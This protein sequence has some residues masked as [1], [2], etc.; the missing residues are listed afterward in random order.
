MKFANSLCTP[1]IIAAI[2]DFSTESPYL[3]LRLHCA[4]C[5]INKA[6]IFGDGFMGDRLPE[7][8]HFFC[9]QVILIDVTAHPIF[10]LARKFVFLNLTRNHYERHQ[11]I[12]FPWKKGFYRSTQTGYAV[13]TVTMV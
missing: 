13:Y 5:V 1:I 2:Q 4:G 7:S 12:V 8:C 6:Q 9:S 10:S 3:V 11:I